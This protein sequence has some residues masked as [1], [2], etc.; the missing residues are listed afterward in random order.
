MG[1]RQD[2]RRP[3][4]SVAAW[5]DDLGSR[6]AHPQMRARLMAG[7]AGIIA[8]GLSACG[9]P[10]TQFGGLFSGR[11]P[12]PAHPASLPAGSGW[13]WKRPDPSSSRPARLP[14]AVPTC[15]RRRS[16]RS[17]PSCKTTSPQ[18]PGP[19]CAWRIQG[20]TSPMLGPTGQ[21]RL[22]RHRR[23]VGA[24]VRW[25]ALRLRA[26]RPSAPAQGRSALQHDPPGQS[27]WK[28][29]TG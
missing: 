17:S 15:S 14:P 3:G 26:C 12:G 22:L 18:H 23:Q 19:R 25:S 20:P 16:P 1:Y 13:R 11:R 2:R 29:G 27:W 6:I 5:P 10:L 9:Y 7:S 4:G 24:W 8:L 28:A 21:A